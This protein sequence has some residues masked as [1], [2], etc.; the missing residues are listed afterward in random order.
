MSFAEII[1]RAGASVGGWLIF[2]ALALILSVMPEASCDP[3]TDEMWRGTFLF[4]ILGFLGL[5]CI[6]Q[7][8]RWRASLRWFAL[9]AA[10]LAVYALFLIAPALITTSLEGG[11]LCSITSAKVPAPAGYQATTIERL[12]PLLQVS[13]LILGL[14][15]CL[16]T[17]LA[18]ADSQEESLP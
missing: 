3:T 8:F 1:L 17:W 15:Q 6:G 18:P 13:V 9:P 16:R 7:G 11:S 12:W 2:I 4:G 14:V 10:G 5:L